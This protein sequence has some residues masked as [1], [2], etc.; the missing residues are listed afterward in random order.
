MEMRELT[1]EDYDA[2]IELWRES[3]LSYRPKGRDSR[4]EMEK[5]MGLIPELFLGAF[6]GQV[7]VGV[8]IGTD[9]T[10]KG[11]VNRLAVR[12][13]HGRRGI[14]T[15]LLREMEERLRRRGNRIIGVLIETPNE[16]SERF[17]EKMGYE[18]YGS[19]AYL[20]KRDSDE[21]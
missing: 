11:W 12:P 18:P 19:I 8:V 7:L 6:E 1:I 5:Q 3:S 17:F 21:V 4:E 16:A 9:D 20:S 13:D 10:R 15:A 14:G 2:I